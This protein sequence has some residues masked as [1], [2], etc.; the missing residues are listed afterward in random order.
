M[1][2]NCEF[3]S[4][5]D[6]GVEKRS[7][8]CYNPATGEVNVRRTHSGE[9]VEMLD[10]EFVEL[11]SGTELE[12]CPTCHEYVMGSIMIPDRIGKGLSEIDVC[13]NKECDSR[14]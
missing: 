8:A 11:P 9:D 4:I 10:R 3:V 12:V 5:W 2:A 6:G 7:P 13:K 14:E 1:K